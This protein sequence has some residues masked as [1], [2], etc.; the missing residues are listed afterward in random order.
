MRELAITLFVR[1]C[2]DE[3]HWSALDTMTA[4]REAF[5]GLS[6]SEKSRVECMFL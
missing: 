6:Y 3:L 4:A 1:H 5:G 2:L